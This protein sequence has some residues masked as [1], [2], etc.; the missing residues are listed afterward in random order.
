[1]YMAFYVLCCDSDS[2][3]LEPGAYAGTVQVLHVTNTS[4]QLGLERAKRPAQCGS[5]S[6]PQDKYTVYYRKV[7][8]ARDGFVDCS[9][10]PSD[11]LTK[12]K[13]WLK[14]SMQ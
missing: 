6:L 14:S 5:I 11:C 3:C 8:E 1:M 2:V 13:S 10:V 4:V 7:V 12:V 9:A